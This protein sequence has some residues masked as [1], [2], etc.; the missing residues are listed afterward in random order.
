MPPDQARIQDTRA[1]LA[2]AGQDL[3][4]VEV[5]LASLEEVEAAR[6]LA[7]EVY[8]AV[9]ARVPAEIHP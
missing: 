2:K 3:R 6:L 8:R 4:R 9:L 1:W 5:L 7:D